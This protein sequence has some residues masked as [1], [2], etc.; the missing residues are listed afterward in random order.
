MLGRRGLYIAQQGIQLR[1][2]LGAVAQGSGSLGAT[3]PASIGRSPYT[4]QSIYT[5][6]VQPIR[7]IARYAVIYIA[8]LPP[9]RYV[10]VQGLLCQLAQDV[11]RILGGLYTLCRR[12]LYVAWLGI[13]LYIQLGYCRLSKQ[14]SR[15]YYASQDRQQPI[16]QGLGL[17]L[18]I[19]LGQW[20]QGGGSLGGGCLGATMLASVGSSPYTRGLGLQLR[21]Q[22]GWQGWGSTGQ[23]LVAQGCYTSQYRIQ[24][25]HQLDYI[26]AGLYS[27]RY[28]LYIYSK[29]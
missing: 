9:S 2:Q 21:V 26:L 1:I 14:Q 19:Q 25:I 4:R 28:S 22:L 11:A 8:R 24:P 12:S 6:Q 17:Q 23:G 5:A 16:Y 7:C 15:G 29:V 18:Y 27:S 3:M 13:Q 10:V 20:G